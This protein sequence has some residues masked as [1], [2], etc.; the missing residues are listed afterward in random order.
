[1]NVKLL[2]LIV[3]LAVLINVPNAYAAEDDTVNLLDLPEHLAA[4]LGIPT[5]AGQL[6]ACTIFTV[7]F[8]FPIAFFARRNM[9][10]TLIAGFVLL[11]FF[12]AVGWLPYWFLLIIVLAIAGLWSGTIREWLS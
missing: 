4:K 9:M 10:L 1:L 12:I 7:M 3:L 6:L 2:L 8:L 11:G 5:F